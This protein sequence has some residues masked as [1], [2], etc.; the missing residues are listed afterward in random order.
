MRMRSEK[1]LHGLEAGCVGWCKVVID[2]RRST[3]WDPDG[4]CISAQSIFT[5]SSLV[6]R[7][8]FFDLVCKPRVWKVVD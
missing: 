3:A 6:L 1:V 7:V 4:A 5:S 8:F 2:D